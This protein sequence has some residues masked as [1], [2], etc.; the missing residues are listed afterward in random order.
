[1]MCSRNYNENITIDALTLNISQGKNHLCDDSI[2]APLTW[3]TFSRYS[4]FETDKVP[5]ITNFAKFVLDPISGSDSRW[6]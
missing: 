3:T 4:I 6:W 5:K 1:M 2:H